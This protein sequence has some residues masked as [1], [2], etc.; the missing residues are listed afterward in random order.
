MG[1]I[2]FAG[3]NFQEEN[4]KKIMLTTCMTA[5]LLFSTQNAFA[6]TS[7]SI[8][9]GMIP[10]APVYA[11]CEYPEEAYI[12]VEGHYCYDQPRRYWVPGH[13]SHPPHVQERYGHR[14][15]AYQRYHDDGHYQSGPHSRYDRD[16]RGDG[17]GAGS[18]R[19]DRDDGQR[20]YRHDQQKS[21][22]GN[23]MKNLNDRV[24]KKQVD[25]RQA[26]H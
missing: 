15:A 6:G 1:L 12:W 16:G 13:W 3:M 20:E 5:V 22:S 17:R 18:Y 11:A 4:M 2:V 19:Y 26:S 25:Y 24:I 10:V 7:I 21:K 23:W 9:L 14:P 8:N